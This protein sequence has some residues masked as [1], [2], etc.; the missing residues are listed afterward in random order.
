MNIK[1]ITTDSTIYKSNELINSI[2][3]LSLQEQR[4]VLI[5]ISMVNPKKDKEFIS[6]EMP[7]EMFKSM[8]GADVRGGYYQE[9][10]EVVKRLMKRSFKVARPEDDGWLR[11]NWLSSCEYKKGEGIIQLEISAKLHPFLLDLKSH[12]TSYRL[13][14]ILPLR[15][16][17][18][19]RLYELLK[20]YEAIG[21]RYLSLEEMRQMMEIK[22]TEYSL[23]A[24]FKRKVILQAQK[25]LKEK[26]DIF[27]E[28]K[29]KKKVRRVIGIYFFIYKNAK[30]QPIE[31]VGENGEAVSVKAANDAVDVDLYERLLKLRFSKEGA[32]ILLAKYDKERLT[33]NIE[34]V[35]FKLRHGEFKIGNV[36]AYT[37]TII[38]N[39]VR[40]QPDLFPEKNAAEQ[41]AIELKNGMVVEFCGTQYKIEGGQ[42]GDWGELGRVEETLIAAIRAG[43]AR[44]ITGDNAP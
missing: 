20:Q 21:E 30:D 5:L 4:I 39:D 1:K 31:M 7:V 29:Q 38:K 36:A 6:F 16:G 13:K 2:F 24:D 32:K 9:L 8:I 40:L 12:Y 14:N 43:E 10:E 17:Y 42:F 27:F 18:S 44:I 41:P 23:Y 26:T 22:N 37:Q 15:S 25:E 33:A 11:I 28:F 34:Y 35:E 3:D 19:I